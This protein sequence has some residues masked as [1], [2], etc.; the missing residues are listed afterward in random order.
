MAN[1]SPDPTPSSSPYFS[2][3]YMAFSKTELGFFIVIY[4]FC[5]V[6]SLLGGILGLTKGIYSYSS[7]TNSA[8]NKPS[9][10]AR[11]VLYE[12]EESVSDLRHQALVDESETESERV[13][14]LDLF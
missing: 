3:F 6:L 4:I 9:S 2:N 14:S 5:F 7:S 1:P 10:A 8:M 12:R 11:K 13:S